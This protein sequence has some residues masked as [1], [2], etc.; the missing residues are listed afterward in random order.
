[1]KYPTTMSDYK[2]VTKAS[3]GQKKGGKRNCYKIERS[4]IALFA[5]LET[6]SSIHQ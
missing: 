5:T 1:M 6:V 2:Q 4:L 3:L